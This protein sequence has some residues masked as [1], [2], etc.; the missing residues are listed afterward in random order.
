MRA[1]KKLK[2]L[3]PVLLAGAIVLLCWTT[4]LGRGSVQF[5][6]LEKDGLTFFRSGNKTFSLAEGAAYGVLND[7]PGFTLPAGHYTLSVTTDGDGDN[8]LRITTSNGAAVEPA[9]FTLPAHGWNST[10]R[11]ELKEDARDLDLQIEFVQGTYLQIHDFD[12][13]MED[14]TDGA[15]MLTLLAVVCCI[16]YG[17]WCRGLLPRERMGRLLLMGAAVLMASVPAL[18][19]NLYG[20][21]DTL[22]HQ[23]RLYNVA[24][25]LRSGQFPVR[26]GGYGYNGYGSAVSVFYPDVFLYFPAFMMLTGAT[27]QC[28]ARAYIIGMNALTAATMYLCGKRIFASRSTGVCASILYTLAS[29]RL[30]DVYVRDA[31]GEYTA[32]AMLPLFILG[33]WEVIFGDARRWRTLVLGATLVFMSHM[34]TT[35]MCAVLAVLI[36]AV[37]LGRIVR[38]KRLAPIL[39]AIM[40]TACLNLFLLLPMLDYSMQGIGDSGTFMTSCSGSAVE[41][42]ELFA[43]QTDSIKN[44]GLALLLGTAVF[45]YA[46]LTGRGEKKPM[47]T[48]IGCAAVGVAAALAATNLFPWARLEQLTRGMIN[49]LQ[50]PWRLLTFA[51]VFLALA[52]GCGVMCFAQGKAQRELAMLLTLVLCVTGSYAQIS[53]YAIQ[54]E[55]MP[56]SG[57]RYADPYIRYKSYTDVITGSYLE[58]ALPGSNLRATSDQSVQLSGAEMTDYR[59]VGTEITANVQAT[60]DAEIALPVFGFD[61]YRATVDGRE[62]ETGLGDNNRLTVLLSEGT[63]GELKVWF[64]GKAIWRAAEIVSLL[65]AA[66]LLFSAWR[67]RRG[68]AR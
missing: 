46:A 10:L 52:A 7:G 5:A 54:D 37:S 22:F 17:C 38:E 61:G 58:Y 29:Y 13:V 63:S 34:L 39:K 50:F 60:A 14:A 23:M 48:A 33:L 51:D 31:L 27:V 3:L 18:R 64:A 59:K 62:M 66:G 43:A 41:L 19:D 47:R 15:W 1:G 2:R 57:L 26:M 8:L 4:G 20:G 12:M 36:G 68:A 56:E 32:M 35:V 67:K 40:A 45:A 42:M 44:L 55:S 16:L 21:H 28:A 9:E 24:D 30:V 53:G 11:F 49:Y 6:N 65:T 25:A